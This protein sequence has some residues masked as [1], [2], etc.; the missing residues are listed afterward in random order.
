M[1]AEELLELLCQGAYFQ[2]GKNDTTV[3][4][5]LLG[6]PEKDVV[7]FSSQFEGANSS[8]KNNPLRPCPLALSKNPLTPIRTPYFMTDRNE[9]DLKEIKLE[10]AMKKRDL[11]ELYYSEDFLG[12]L[13]SRLL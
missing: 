4:G 2:E 1:S 9:I 8:K 6:Y 12:K 3:L 10:Y 7:A 13:L 5:L 11:V